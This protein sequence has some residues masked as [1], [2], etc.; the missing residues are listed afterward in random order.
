MKSLWEEPMKKSLVSIVV[1]L[2]TLFGLGA[3]SPANATTYTTWRISYAGVGPAKLNMTIPQAL[4]SGYFTS[5]GC[6]P[7]LKGAPGKKVFVWFRGTNQTLSALFVTAATSSN[8]RFATKTGVHV[9][10]TVGQ[11][12]QGESG[13]WLSAKRVF[14]GYTPGM[15]YVYYQRS[16]LHHWMMYVLPSTITSPRQIT[17]YTKLVEIAVS[18]YKLGAIGGC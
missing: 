10:S 18:N 17:R 12:K 2:A 8:Y 5:G 7:Q 1:A 11:L 13:L 6:S 4:A 14:A 16:D 3:L 9:G 15:S